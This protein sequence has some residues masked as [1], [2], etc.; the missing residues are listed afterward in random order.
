MV[1]KTLYNLTEEHLTIMH[2]VEQMDGELT[3]DAVVALELN[4]A[5]VQTKALAYC[6]VINNK[7]M[8][9][10]AIDNEIKRLQAMKKSE[11]TN[12]ERLKTTLSNA[13]E[14]LGEIHTGTLRLSNRMSTAV[15]VLDAAQLPAHLCVT[16][17]ELVPDKNAI[18]TALTNGEEVP[19]AKLVFN[20]NLQIP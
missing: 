7:Q 12:M 3:D 10:A 19:G 15:E 1:N 14:V 18:K 8:R 13:V 6:E 16:K 17:V 11:Q 2:E 9:I 5:N 20:K 4:V